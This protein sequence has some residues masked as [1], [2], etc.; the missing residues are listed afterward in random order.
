MHILEEKRKNYELRK[1][2]IM[3]LM[4]TFYNLLQYSVVL[5]IPVYIV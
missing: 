5:S 1:Q 3:S 4:E 2:N